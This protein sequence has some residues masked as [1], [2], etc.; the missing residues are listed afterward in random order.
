MV[1][2]GRRSALAVAFISCG[3]FVVVAAA[4]AVRERAALGVILAPVEPQDAVEARPRILCQL[5]E[6]WHK[7]PRQYQTELLHDVL[8][9]QTLLSATAASS[10]LT[11]LA[12]YQKTLC[13]NLQC[14]L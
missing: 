13:S 4:A 1:V 5:T 11:L 2:V 8:V 10:T 14:F 12:W 3:E 7:Q 6:F 9:V